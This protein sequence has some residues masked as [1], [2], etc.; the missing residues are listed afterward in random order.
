MKL[1]ELAQEVFWEYFHK[2]RDDRLKRPWKENLFF[3]PIVIAIV[4]ALIV[5]IQT[6]VYPGRPL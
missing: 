6:F 5:L 3:I 1:W 4:V 2:F